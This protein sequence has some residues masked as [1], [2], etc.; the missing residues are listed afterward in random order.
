MKTIFFSGLC[1]VLVILA[2]GCASERSYPT[3]ARYIDSNTLRANVKSALW[4]DPVVN[5]FD[6]GVG[7]YRSNVQLSGVV[8]TP[9]QKRRA[10]SVALA[11]PGVTS[12]ANDLMI[13]PVGLSGVGAGPRTEIRVVGEDPSMLLPRVV[14]NPDVYYGKNVEVQGTVDTVL[15]PNSFTLNSAGVREHPLLVVTSEREVHNISPGD[16]VRV[17]GELEP[18][19]RTAVS[20]RLNADLEPRKFDGWAN[21]AALLADSIRRIKD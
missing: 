6:I 17:R 3:A 21:R 16:V 11:V 4:Q 15:S 13:R 20:Q 1:A 14:G 10:E 19:N 9:E 12:V 2:S 18:F 7:V 8:D 5:G